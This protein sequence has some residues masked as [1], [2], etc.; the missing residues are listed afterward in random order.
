MR[1]A[2]VGHAVFA[3]TLIAL[4]VLGLIQGGFTP[5]WGGVPKDLPGREVLA[6]VCAIVSLVSGVGLLW[7]RAAAVT[8]CGL[9]TYFLIWLL[10]FRASHFLV[11]PTA[12]D[13]WWGC[14]DTAVMLAAAWVLHAWFA[15]E[16]NRPRLA[17]VAGDKGI[18]VARV[19]YGL[20]M[21][22][23]G[24]AHF[25]YLK[26]TA[27]L[28]PGWLPWH[29]AWACFTGGAF[30]AAGAA[31]LIGVYARLAAVLSAL[32]MGLFTLLVWVPIVVAG[33]TPYQWI[34]FLDSWA[35]TAAAWVVADSYRGGTWLANRL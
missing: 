5:T 4:G 29:T 30:I 19:F 24:V 34:E 2:S 9:L 6:Y 12:V 31:V 32:Q 16:Q 35:L 18:R 10:L 25:I 11:A 33:P 15:G 21:L 8:S 27:D 20:A 23:F 1:I 3:V 26:E 7:R 17:L 14:G 22:P 13:T 28:V